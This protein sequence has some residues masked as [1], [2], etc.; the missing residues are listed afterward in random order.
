VL[1]MYIKPLSISL[2]HFGGRIQSFPLDH[3]ESGRT[4]K[5]VK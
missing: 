4:P 1:R 3:I 2:I 5:N